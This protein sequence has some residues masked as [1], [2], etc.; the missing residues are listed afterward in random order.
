MGAGLPTGKP[1]GLKGAFINELHNK[2]EDG[3]RLGSLTFQHVFTLSRGLTPAVISRSADDGA[4]A[5]GPA[6]SAV[7][8][9]AE[10]ES[11]RASFSRAGCENKA[12]SPYPTTANLWRFPLPRPCCKLAG[13]SLQAKVRRTFS[14]LEGL[15]F[16]VQR[17]GHHPNNSFDRLVRVLQKLENNEVQAPV[18][19]RCYTQ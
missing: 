2:P 19:G 11:E 8:S 17:F 15:E 13:M 4:Q 6:N 18:A 1:S 10:E 7:S 5:Q 14:L 12:T 16:R 9:L 3:P